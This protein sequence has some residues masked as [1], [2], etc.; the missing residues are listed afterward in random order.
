MVNPDDKVWVEG[1]DVCVLSPPR[2]PVVIDDVDPPKVC[3]VR[4]LIASGN[5]AVQSPVCNCNACKGFN[6]SSA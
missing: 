2:S 3:E 6:E 1:D 5:A 4:P